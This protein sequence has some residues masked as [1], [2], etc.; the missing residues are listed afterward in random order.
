MVNVSNKH[1]PI[2]KIGYSL[3]KNN[4]MPQKLSLKQ[5][6]YYDKLIARMQK[7]IVDGF[8]AVQRAVT[9]QG[10]KT[11]WTAGED[12]LAIVEE[13]GGELRLGRSLYQRISRDLKK[14]IDLD[15][16]ADK[17]GRMVQFRRKYPVFP[18][19]TPLGFTHYLA[20]L[21]IDDPKKRAQLE[22]RAI[23]SGMSVDA[24][25]AEVARIKG[26]KKAL[27]QP[28]P[29]MDEHMI[30]PCQRGEPYV[31]RVFPETPLSGKKVFRVDCGFKIN[32]P[33]PLNNAYRPT[34]ARVVR[35]ARQEDGTYQ[36]RRFK[37]SGVDRPEDL[38][39]TYAARVTNVIDGD[40]L[41]VRIDIGFGIS[42]SDR[43]RL[44]G[45]NAKEMTELKGR[46]AKHF[47]KTYLKECPVVILRTEKEGMF[48]RWIADLFAIQG[49]DDI[50]KIAAEG[51]YINQFLLDTGYA[52][53]Y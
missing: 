16:S 8:A 21:R 42:V 41:D 49:C 43:L 7:T 45:I 35:S 52:E 36:I 23:R 37:D 29:V 39:Y 6:R 18:E 10:L 44:K 1:I 25:I 19:N 22:R 15:A 27:A 48:G 38:L 46:Q 2:K 53:V 3:F 28:E 4:F 51:L 14:N 33:V 32:V 13:S 5:S 31:Y 24:I 50:Y 9:Y 17:V 11:F 26:E 30:L 12:V 40:T 34:Q 47:L 20:L